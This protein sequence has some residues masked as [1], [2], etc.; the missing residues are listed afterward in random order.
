M[1]TPPAS[2]P[3]LLR[4]NAAHDYIAVVSSS[5][6]LVTGATGFVG[7]AMLEHLR[8]SVSGAD[9]TP[10][11][12]RAAVRNAG[13][14]AA[15]L[16]L[17]IEVSSIGD[18]D[19]MTR[20]EAALQGIDAVLHLA[21]VAHQRSSHD[22]AARFDSVNTQGTH[23]LATQ[24][25]DAGVRRF[26]FVSSVKAN[27]EQTSI[28]APFQ[29]HVAVADDPAL[30]D[31]GRSKARAELK[32]QELA[33]P[34]VFDVVIVRP[35]LVYGHGVRANFAALARAVALGIPLPLG[36]IRNLRSLVYVENLVDFLATV[37]THP[38]AIN[39]IFLVSDGMDV[40]TP[41]L[42]RRMAE[43]LGV[44][45][46]LLPC[47]PALLRLAGRVLPAGAGAMDRLIGSLRVDSGA[48]RDALGWTPPFTLDQ[49][50]RRT[51]RPAALELP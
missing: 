14:G 31:Y 44:P 21:G 32:L 35:P 50:L 34:G 19:G 41:E 49:A 38:N 27:G 1:V 7:R 11:I 37:L 8:T 40:S 18:I 3:A 17:G 46:R 16:P 13:R 45:A 20:W 10:W 6:V 42:V 25:R 15:P 2:G 12:V 39:R 28:S 43:A 30:D 48:A 4:P 36:S 9:Q 33:V 24:A 23:R 26:V 29:P 22:L 51:F 5:H 47:P